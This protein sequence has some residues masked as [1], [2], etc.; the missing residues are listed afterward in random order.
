MKKGIVLFIICLLYGGLLVTNAQST[1]PFTFYGFVRTD[2]Y[3]DS[4]QI[5]ELREGLMLLYP[6]NEKKD[7]NNAD[8]NNVPS[9]NFSPIG[10]RIGVKIKGPK[11][12][13]AETMGVVEAEFFG[14][15]NATINTLRLR[16]SYL[17]MNWT[18]SELLMGQTWHPFFTEDCI[19]A[20]VSFNTGAPFQPFNRS[21]Q[22]R[23]TQKFGNMSMQVT[24]LNER[25]FA[26]TGP[27]GVSI[28][29][30]TTAI[31]P[32]FTAG[33]FYKTNLCDSSCAL[34]M[35][36]LGEYKTLRPRSVTDSNY[37]T[38]KTISS[39]SVT[40]FVK[41]KTSKF[42]AKI[43]GVYGQNMYN[44]LMLGGYAVRYY[45]VD[46]PDRGDWEYTTLDVASAWVDLGY[47]VSDKLAFGVFGGY[48][49]NLGS[50]K[51]IQNWNSNTTYFSRNPDIAYIY[52]VSPRAQFFRGKTQ[53]SLETEYTVAAY[54]SKR[55]SLGIVQDKSDLY[56]SAVINEIN[57]LRILFALIY[58]F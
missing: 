30:M 36:V 11:A 43:K 58:T 34:S 51:N 4:R 22:V 27:A 5:L 50:T 41:F 18:N 31:I 12:C 39:S 15:S 26:S 17:K 40:A 46:V 20:T 35:G 28:T 24:A 42:E 14:N 44:Q 54:G 1:S 49:Q 57:N 23:F 3:Y 10:S 25:D 45:G 8:I 55:N 13:G 33:L 29:Y 19:P 37:V 52:R 38:N 9:Y 56:P 16:H 47:K 48:E 32:E 7:V 21:P 6:L 53:F 2:A